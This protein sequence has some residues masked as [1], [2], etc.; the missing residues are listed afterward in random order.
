VLT[1]FSAPVQTGPGPHPSS[2]TTGTGSF[3][4]VK[5][6]GRG[7]NHIPPCSAKVKERVELYLSLSGPSWPV[8]GRKLS[9]PLF[10]NRVPFFDL[11]FCY[12]RPLFQKR[13][14]QYIK[15]CACLCQ[16]AFIICK[17][18]CLL[19][20]VETI[21]GCQHCGHLLSVMAYNSDKVR[22]KLQVNALLR[23]ER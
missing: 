17:Y 15:S 22:R 12:L 19:L 4:G 23:P 11:P 1:K 10:L 16:C 20:C 7:V 14:S 18:C 8:L 13:Y 3:Q 2:Y 6:S 21:A 9:N 5:R